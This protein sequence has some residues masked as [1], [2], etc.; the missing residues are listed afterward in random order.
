MR[1]EVVSQERGEGG[2]YLAPD[3]P[4]ITGGPRRYTTPQKEEGKQ[5]NGDQEPKKL[6]VRQIGA[7]S[8]L[9]YGLLRVDRF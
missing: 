2:G 7:T 8:A 4:R 1:P 9:G 5:E 6:T 3:S